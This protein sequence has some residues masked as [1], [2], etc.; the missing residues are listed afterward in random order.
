MSHLSKYDVYVLYLRYLFCFIEF[1][2]CMWSLFVICK[3]SK[4]DILCGTVFSDV[5]CRYMWVAACDFMLRKQENHAIIIITIM[6]I[7]HAL[8]NALST[9]M[10]HINL[11][12]I[13]INLNMIFYMHVEHSPTKT[14][15]MKYYTETHTHTH[16]HKP[17]QIQMCMTLICITLCE[18]CWSGHCFTVCVNCGFKGSCR[19]L[20]QVWLYSL[21]VSIA[22]PW[23][24]VSLIKTVCYSCCEGLFVTHYH[25]ASIP[26]HALRLQELSRSN[27]IK[28]IY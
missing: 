23:P 12:M 20:A 5:C 26:D 18:L 25:I 19:P 9:H 4:W 13:F 14:M 7:Y 15:Y 21:P 28:C 2:H 16:T 3:L 17:Q 27:T 11:N 1:L 22:L 10:I 24:L 6:Y 8:I